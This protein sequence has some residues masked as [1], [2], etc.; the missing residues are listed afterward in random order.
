[1]AITKDGDIFIGTDKGLNF[2]AAA[3]LEQLNSIGGNT[4]VNDINIDS[5]GRI[6]VATDNGLNI[7]LDNGM[8]WITYNKDSGMASNNIIKA[9]VNT[10]NNSIWTASEA[11]GLSYSD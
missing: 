10:K 5:E 8:T 7:S 1:M 9:T 2:G 3:N 6:I 11:D 4:K